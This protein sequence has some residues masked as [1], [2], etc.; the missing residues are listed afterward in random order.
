MKSSVAVG[1]VDT[2]GAAVGGPGHTTLEQSIVVVHV[3]GVVTWPVSVHS[4]VPLNESSNA[5]PVV[6]PQHVSVARVSSP[7]CVSMPDDVPHTGQY[8]PGSV[9]EKSPIVSMMSSAVAVV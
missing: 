4:H 9:V 5:A 2:V 6:S 8:E 1:A 3:A 7:F